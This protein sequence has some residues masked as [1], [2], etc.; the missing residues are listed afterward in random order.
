MGRGHASLQNAQSLLI[1]LMNT[2]EDQTLGENG[3][4]TRQNIEGETASKR[5]NCLASCHV[6]QP[7]TK[8]C[9]GTCMPG[10]HRQRKNVPPPGSHT[11]IAFGERE[12]SEQ[13]KVKSLVLG[14]SANKQAP[15]K[16]KQ[17][18]GR[19]LQKRGVEIIVKK[20]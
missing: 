7:E 15:E 12:E 2:H 5:Q 18:T 3:K 9:F 17:K 1:G 8:G 14:K 4:T 6:T 10:T 11:K 20:R 16:P 13:I 19:K